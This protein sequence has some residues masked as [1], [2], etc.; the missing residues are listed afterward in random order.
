MTTRTI[1]TLGSDGILT[2]AQRPAAA[3]LT[4]LSGQTIQVTQTTIA[5]GLGSTPSVV[6]ISP[7]GVSF[8]YESQEADATNVYMTAA[9]ITTADIYVAV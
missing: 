3:G 1:A 5:H 2:S 8:V 7:R 6:I 9:G 4:K